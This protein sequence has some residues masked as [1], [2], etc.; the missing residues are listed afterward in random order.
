MTHPSPGEVCEQMSKLPS[1]LCHLNQAAGSAHSVEQQSAAAIN[2]TRFMAFL[3]NA[4][5]IL[6]FDYPACSVKDANSALTGAEIRNI[7]HSANRANT[8]NLVYS[9]VFFLLFSETFYNP[10]KVLK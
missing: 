8:A 6:F 9:P 5:Q 10:A 2:K 1:G 3:N 7:S 4:H